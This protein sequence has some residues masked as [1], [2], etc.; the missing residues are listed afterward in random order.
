VAGTSL[1]VW[2]SWQ[3][4]HVRWPFA[5]GVTKPGVTERFVQ[6]FAERAR[7]HF[8]CAVAPHQP[9]TPFGKSVRVRP[10]RALTCASAPPGGLQS[11]RERT[12]KTNRNNTLKLRAHSIRTLTRSELL[13]ANG[14]KSYLPCGKSWTTENPEPKHNPNSV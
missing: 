7:Q 12:M 6:Y 11:N 14:G 8:R 13:V 9:A 3:P 10:L 5:V 2:A 1:R 4:V